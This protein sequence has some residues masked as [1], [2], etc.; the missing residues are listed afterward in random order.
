MAEG[1]PAG[2]TPELRP[3][4]R[5][6][7]LPH[8]DMAQRRH[9]IDGISSGDH[10]VHEGNGLQPSVGAFV[11]RNAQPLVSQTVQAGFLGE[12]QDQRPAA[13]TKLGHQMTRR[14]PHAVGNLHLRDCLSFSRRV[15]LC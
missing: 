8:A 10:A 3:L 5:A 14:Q 9:V 4:K 15:A 6:E 13:D 7:E 11:R 1:N 12:F 2:A